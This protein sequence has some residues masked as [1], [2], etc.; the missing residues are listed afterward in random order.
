MR[1]GLRRPSR[2]PGSSIGPVAAGH[3]SVLSHARV[4]DGLDWAA[5]RPIK[6]L[7]ALGYSQ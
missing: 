1:S 2:G 6:T 4:R 7:R 3:S 5:K